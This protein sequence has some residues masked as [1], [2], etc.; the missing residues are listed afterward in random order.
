MS[1]LQKYRQAVK[2]RL[3]TDYELV[4]KKKF[5]EPE[6]TVEERIKDVNLQTVLG[7]RLRN[8]G[9]KSDFEFAVK[10][11]DRFIVMSQHFL[12]AILIIHIV[13]RYFWVGIK[14]RLVFI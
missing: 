5:S 2:D 9:V 11:K 1:S 12:T 3:G 14:V 6:R 8:N 7:E 4:L 13:N 10:E